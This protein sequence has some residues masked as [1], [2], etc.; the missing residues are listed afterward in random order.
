[1]TRQ[2][3]HLRIPSVTCCNILDKEVHHGGDKFL[4]VTLGR[5]G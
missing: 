2:M 3:V 1:M 5:T 4:V